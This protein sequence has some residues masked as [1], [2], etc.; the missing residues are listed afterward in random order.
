[1]IQIYAPSTEKLQQDQILISTSIILGEPLDRPQLWTLVDLQVKIWI[2]MWFLSKTSNKNLGG[3]PWSEWAPEWGNYVNT[4]FAQH[5]D[6]GSKVLPEYPTQTVWKRGGQAEVIWQITANHGGGYQYRL[7]PLTSQPLTESCFQNMPLD[8][9]KG[10]QFLQWNNG[11]RLKINPTYVSEGT[12]P[13]NSTWAMNPIP[14]R[15]LGGGCAQ[16]K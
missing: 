6:F 15:C 7:C 12:V 3:T 8:F 9:V 5:G 14:P 13:E 4:S 16:G 10:Q 2:L 11:T 1:M